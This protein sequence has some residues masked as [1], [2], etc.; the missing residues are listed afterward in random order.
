M[1]THARPCYQL[2]SQYTQN[3][4]KPII[5]PTPAETE[6]QLYAYFKPN[7]LSQKDYNL[8]KK[9]YGTPS[10]PASACTSY[11]SVSQMCGGTGETP[12]L[13]NDQYKFYPG[14]NEVSTNRYY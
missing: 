4:M 11:A 2:L 12:E 6:P 10:Q 14:F 8:H 9:M 3:G 7:H 5:A 13:L 1:S